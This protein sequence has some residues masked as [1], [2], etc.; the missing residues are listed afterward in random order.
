[1]SWVSKRALDN[2]NHTLA[3]LA[4]GEDVRI[5]ESHVSVCGVIVVDAPW[6]DERKDCPTCRPPQPDNPDFPRRL[7]RHTCADCGATHIIGRNV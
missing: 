2:L 5:I 4:A 7:P 1:M 6:S 3:P